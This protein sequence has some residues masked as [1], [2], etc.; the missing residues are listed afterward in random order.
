[1][2]QPGA[3]THD[4]FPCRQCRGCI[5]SAY[6]RC[7][8]YQLSKGSGMTRMLQ[9]SQIFR[10]AESKDGNDLINNTQLGTFH[11]LQL[12]HLEFSHH[13]SRQFTGSAADKRWTNPPSDAVIVCYTSCCRVNQPVCLVIQRCHD[14]FA[15]INLHLDVTDKVYNLIAA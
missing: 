12:Q 8:W 9:F 11:L 5:C 15:H 13:T 4:C 1:M 7:L 3:V 2:L 6:I 10:K 14:S